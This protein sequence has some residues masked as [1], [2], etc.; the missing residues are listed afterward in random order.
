M[1]RVSKKAKKE[2]EAF[3]IKKNMRSPIRIV[4]TKG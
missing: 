4:E 3:F 2:I 1:V